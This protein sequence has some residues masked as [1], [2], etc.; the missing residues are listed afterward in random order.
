MFIFYFTFIA[1]TQV[2]SNDK[3]YLK[4]GSVLV[5]KIIEYQPKDSV[6]FQIQDGKTMTFPANLVKKVKMYSE[7]EVA[8]MYSFRQNTSD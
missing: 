1:N 2:P 5:G 8:K 6:V 7:S 4:N 3:I